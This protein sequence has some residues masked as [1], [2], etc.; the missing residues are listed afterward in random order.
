MDRTERLGKE[1]ARSR[2]QSVKDSLKGG[3]LF[4]LE[5]RRLVEI[6]K[7]TKDNSK[8]KKKR[9]EINSPGSN[10]EQGCGVSITE[11]FWK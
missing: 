9:K 3:E 4:N 2:E 1:N 5:M 8:K 11:G 6:F 10:A 7:Y